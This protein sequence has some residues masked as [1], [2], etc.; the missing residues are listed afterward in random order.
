MYNEYEFKKG[1]LMRTRWPR[2]YMAIDFDPVNPAIL[3]GISS[4]FHMSFQTCKATYWYDTHDRNHVAN[5]D[6]W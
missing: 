3:Y 2:I 6:K 5:T 4:N 1:S